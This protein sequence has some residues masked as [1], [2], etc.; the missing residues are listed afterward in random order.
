[1]VGP[2]VVV[3][4]L[5]LAPQAPAQLRPSVGLA[6]GYSA[7]FSVRQSAC[8]R[9]CGGS[10]YAQ[11]LGVALFAQVLYGEGVSI[12]AHAEV[13]P[14]F[15]YRFGMA[16]SLLAVVRFGEEW[17]IDVGAGLGHGWA[18]RPSL[19]DPSVSVS[20][21]EVGGAFALRAG[22]ML[23]ESWG[24]AARG[25]AITGYPGSLSAT[26]GLEWRL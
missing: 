26:V 4:V 13:A 17:F 16:T 15:G 24:V 1:M 11:G 20:R 21:G 8:I 23:D 12:G 5:V 9:E 25:H 3:L 18:T 14:T 10:I 2:S 22:M 19:E 7:P 6:L